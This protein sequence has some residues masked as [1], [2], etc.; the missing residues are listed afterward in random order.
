MYLNEEMRFL[1]RYFIYSLVIITDMIP[2]LMIILKQ[3]F[4][5]VRIVEGKCVEKMKDNRVCI[6]NP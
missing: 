5:F 2:T 3:Y 4:I 6:T 1:Y